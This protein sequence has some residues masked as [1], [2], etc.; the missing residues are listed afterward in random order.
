MRACA[1]FLAV[2]ALAAGCADVGPKRVAVYPVAGKVLFNGQPAERAMVVF[3]PLGANDPRALRPLATVAADGT[4]RLTTYTTGDGAPEGEYAV[5]ITWP[6]G[7]PPK[8]PDDPPP[9]RLKGRYAN[10]AKSPWKVTVKPG[11]NEVEPFNV[12]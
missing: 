4:F 1:T 3:H 8:D 5:T 9:D 2:T 12:Q 7:P 6:G 11:P 10:P